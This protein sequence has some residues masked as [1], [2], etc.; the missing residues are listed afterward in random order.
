[1]VE[2]ANERSRK[3]IAM[4]KLNVIKSKKV[5]PRNDRKKTHAYTMGYSVKV[6]NTVVTI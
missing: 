2:L 1:M 5:K 4:V 3:W 6:T